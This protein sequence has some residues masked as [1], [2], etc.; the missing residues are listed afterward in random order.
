MMK[1]LDRSREK[2]NNRLLHI[3][4]G[5]LSGFICVLMVLFPAMTLES[6]KRGIQLWASCV[7][8]AL[9]PFFICANFMITLGIPALFGRCFEGLF[10]KVFR[11]PG[12]AAF[13]FFMSTTSGYPMGAKL[14]GD[15]RKEG[16]ITRPEAKRM[17]AFCTTTGPLFIL[18]AVGANMLHSPLMGAVIA[19]AHYS[20]AVIN[21]IL[22]AVFGEKEDHLRI[23]NDNSGNSCYYKTEACRIGNSSFLTE[24][25]EAILSSIRT[26]VVICGYLVMFCLMTDF[27]EASGILSFL[28]DPVHQGLVKGAVEMTLGCNEIAALPAETMA[29]KCACCA[30]LISF[31]GCSVL[32]QSMSVLQGSGITIGEYV[33]RK[34]THGIFTA[35]I[36]YALASVFLQVTYTVG[37]F[38]QP[39][40]MELQLSAMYRFVFSMKMIGIVSIVMIHLVI[41]N[42][43]WMSWKK[44]RAEI[45]KKETVL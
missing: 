7:L 26:L 14:I 42:E 3:L 15:L 32:F 10:R 17:A 16:R 38:P 43:W 24:F 27:M 18:G 1:M 22:F 6:A 45:K 28:S 4:V 44:K 39:V 40:E 13:V 29:L 36:A 19:V 31:G 5:I 8:P 41:F 30:F 34:L 37:V 9:L 20:G 23:K 2:Q 11:V 25:T 21:G 33:L 12:I 35:G